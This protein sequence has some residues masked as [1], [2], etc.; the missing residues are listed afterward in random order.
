MRD[1]A[2]TAFTTVSPKSNNNAQHIISAPMFIEGGGIRKIDQISLTSVSH[3]HTCWLAQFYHLF[4]DDDIENDND[5]NNNNSSEKPSTYIA[6][7]N[8]SKCD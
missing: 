7:F 1:R 2:F 4:F 8:F 5:I 6:S 3:H